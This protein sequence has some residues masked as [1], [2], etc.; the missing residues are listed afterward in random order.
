M[1]VFLSATCSNPLYVLQINHSLATVKESPK[2][3][4]GMMPICCPG[5]L[6]NGIDTITCL[7]NGEWELETAQKSDG[8]Y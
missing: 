5:F 1:F 8:Q 6:I 4:F 2:P 3:E 7:E